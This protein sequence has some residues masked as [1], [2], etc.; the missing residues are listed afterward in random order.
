VVLW[1]SHFANG[2]AQNHRKTGRKLTPYFGGVKS[3]L[4]TINDVENG[5][6]SVSVYM[7]IYYVY[8]GYAMVILRS[9]NKLIPRINVE[10]EGKIY[11]SESSQAWNVLKLKKELVSEFPQ[12]KEKGSEFSYRLV[13]YR[14]SKEFERATKKLVKQGIYVSRL[15][16]KSLHSKT[17]KPKSK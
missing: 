16:V 12:L 17:Y 11:Y 10:S 1:Q 14:N 6:R 8:V 4:S 13:C 15:H 2:G 7:Y 9:N 3:I 5:E